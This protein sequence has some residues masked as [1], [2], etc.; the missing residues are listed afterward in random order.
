MRKNGLGYFALAVS[1]A[2][3][4]APRP[5]TSGP[6]PSAESGSLFSRVLAPTVDTVDVRERNVARVI[7]QAA[8]LWLSLLVGA[9]IVPR[10]L[11]LF[12]LPPTR[13][14]RQRDR[15]IASHGCRAP[16]GMPI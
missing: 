15:N 10:L 1:I 5:A 12:S 2:V 3:V 9:V 13:P 14:R 11:V 7:A 4:F 8:P 16:P 6:S